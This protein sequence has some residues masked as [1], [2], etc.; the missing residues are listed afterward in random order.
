MAML[1]IGESDV[2]LPS[3]F[4]ALRRREPQLD[5]IRRLMFAVLSDAIECFARL[6]GSALASRH[7]RNSHRMSVR[8]REAEAWI[9]AADGGVFG[10]ENVCAS[11]DIE[12][13]GFRTALFR[14][15]ARIHAG[16]P[17]RMP[18]LARGDR[19]GDRP[20]R[21]AVKRKRN[22]RAREMA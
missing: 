10:F 5:P 12:A 22:R 8:A 2:L 14:W 11:L 6:S 21:M 9:Q 19:A 13:D 16:A 15:R 1:E 17:V 20:L 7:D 4:Y 18:R 3:Q